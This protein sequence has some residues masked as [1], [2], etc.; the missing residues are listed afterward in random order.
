[1]KFR[2]WF[3]L[4]GI[5]SEIKRI[6]WLSK[7]QLAQNSAI[8]LLFCFVLGLYFFAGDAVIALIFKA[9]GIN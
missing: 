6:S 3:S 1:M 2:D 7:K 4:K 9:L 8:V 5:R